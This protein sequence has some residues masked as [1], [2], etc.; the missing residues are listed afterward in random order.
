MKKIISILL[1]CLGILGLTSCTNKKPAAPAEWDIS[2]VDI[3]D[4]KQ[5]FPEYFELSAESGI[6][7]YVWQMAEKSYRCGLLERTDRE[8]ADE[9]IWDLWTTKALTVDEARAILVELGA[10]DKD[11]T[12]IPNS[13]P[14]SSYYYVIDDGYT[15]RVTA[16]FK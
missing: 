2:S 13:S 1:V 7:V 3:A 10:E 14:L 5:R 6:E 16:M 8:K 15:E 4:L 12:V 9:E 11:I